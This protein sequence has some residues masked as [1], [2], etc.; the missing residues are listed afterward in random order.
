MNITEHGGLG[1]LA[2]ET[3][4]R[5]GVPYMVTG[6]VASFLYGEIRATNDLD[7]VIAP[8]LESLN[9][10]VDELEHHA[11]VTRKAALD[12]FR[13]ASMFNVIG[14]GTGEKVDFIL[15]KDRSYSRAAFERRTRMDFKSLPLIV[16][17]AEDSILSKLSWARRSGSERQ[18]R[19]VYGILGN[20]E[21][22]L[23]WEYLNYW[24]PE[25]GVVALLNQLRS[26][27][28]NESTRD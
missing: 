7:V 11:H 16:T 18:L 19:D 13:R 6:S 8:D 22:Q 26:D 21:L 25:L 15:L 28:E 20:N 5:L 17:T 23:D 2:I 1:R 3:L 14:N 24:A 4:E 27:L 12:A 10:L 9:A